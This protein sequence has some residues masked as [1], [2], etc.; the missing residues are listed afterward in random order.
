M[1]HL[2]KTTAYALAGCALMF[3]V[4]SCGNSN[5]STSSTTDTTST[6]TTSSNVD[7]MN[8]ANNNSAA[9]NPNAAFVNEVTKSNNTEIQWLQAG[10][11]NGT[12]KMLK[13]DAKKMLKDHKDLA[14]KMQKYASQNNITPTDTAANAD[15]TA[16]NG[17]TGKDWD[18]A[19]AAKMVDAHQQTI[20]KFNQ[21]QNTVTDANLKTI[22]TN[23]LPTLHQ[24]LDMMQKLQSNLK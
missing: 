11:D 23:T 9:N 21:A 14:D 2:F 10:I 8:A 4:A 20:D 16:M 19:W 24:H 13:D 18:Q 12:N 15:M 1:N 6:A 17:K 7:S 22:I 5:N 3:S